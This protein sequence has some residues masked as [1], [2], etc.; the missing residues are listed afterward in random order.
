VRFK[1]TESYKEPYV[2]PGTKRTQPTTAVTLQVVL[3]YSEE[4]SDATSVLDT[5]RQH[6]Y[7]V[8]GQWRW[9]VS[10]D[11]ATAAKDDAC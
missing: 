9:I 7:Q 2:V 1:P 4:G 8:G 3:T 10:P 5:F 6:A 11:V